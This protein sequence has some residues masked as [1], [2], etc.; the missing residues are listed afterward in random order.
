LF[1]VIL[2]ISLAS[3]TFNKIDNVHGVP[4]LKNKSKLLKI[5][6]SNKNDIVTLLGPAPLKNDD[7]KKWT[8]FEVRETKS[9]YGKE[10]IYVN[11]YIEFY[12]NKYGVINKMEQYDL[13]SMNKVTFTKEITKSM[14]VKD[15]F[16][17]NLFSSTRKRME[18]LKNKNKN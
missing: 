13:K 12:F 16:S 7:E 3:C 15:T 2:T 11:D 17:K 1:I 9:R 10:I 5:N 6:Q 8:Y 14:G 18:N 4:N